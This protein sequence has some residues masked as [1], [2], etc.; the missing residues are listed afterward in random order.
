MVVGIQTGVNQCRLVFEEDSRPN[1]LLDWQRYKLLDSR[2]NKLL[3]WRETG[4]KRE[5]D[6][7]LLLGLVYVTII[8]ITCQRQDKETRTHLP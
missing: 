7:G 2:Q 4:E 6:I 1:L 5:S 8:S 3:D